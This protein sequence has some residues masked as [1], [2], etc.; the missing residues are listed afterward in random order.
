MESPGN[1]GTLQRMQ[2]GERLGNYFTWS[3]AG[4][5]ENGNWLVWNKDNT[6]KI[7][8]NEATTE[9]KRVTGNGLPKFTASLSNTFSSLL[10]KEN[11]LDM[12]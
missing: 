2:E 12:I 1:P 5:D 11:I 4:I 6:E 3:Y 7:S 9:D 8:I 10:S